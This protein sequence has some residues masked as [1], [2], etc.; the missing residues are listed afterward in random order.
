[1]PPCR[2]S[3]RC[4]VRRSEVVHVAG[5][6]NPLHDIDI[7]NTELL[8]P[9]SIPSKKGTQ[10]RASGEKHRDARSKRGLLSDQL[11]EVLQAGRPARTV[12][13]TEEEKAHRA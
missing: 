8:L 3:R 5:G 6:V 9:I 11:L 13:L 4:A 2:R 12:E 10:G 1:V 7:I